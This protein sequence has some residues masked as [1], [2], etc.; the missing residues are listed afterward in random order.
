MGPLQRKVLRVLYGASYIG[1]S[2]MTCREIARV[3][4]DTHTEK[5]TWESVRA[6]MSGMRVQHGRRWVK[7][8]FQY[9]TNVACRLPFPPYEIYDSTTY[10]LITDAGEMALL[11]GVRHAA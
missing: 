9:H 8:R 10:W 4:S 11:D 3:I 1:L 5:T 7:R 6:A 2:G